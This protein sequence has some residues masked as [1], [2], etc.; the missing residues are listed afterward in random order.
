MKSKQAEKIIEKI[1]IAISDIKRFSNNSEL[2]KSYLAKFLV[3]YICGIYEEVIE[4]IINEKVS[5]SNDPEVC[6]YVKETLKNNFRNPDM[7]NIKGLL[8]KFDT[9]WKLEICKL[10]QDSQTAMDN[11]VNDK[12]SLAHGNDVSLTLIDILEYY[13]N[14]LAV[15]K[16]I[17]DL[18]L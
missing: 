5:S 2:E 4:T 10:P 16:K 15:I 6:N 12:N 8:S 3:V 7:G 14:S 18:L 9:N 17:D 13:N 1:D 11:I